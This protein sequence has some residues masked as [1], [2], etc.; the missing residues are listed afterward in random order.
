MSA[1]TTADPAAQELDFL[2]CRT[3]IL[4]DTDDTAGRFGL[5][6]SIEVPAGHMPPVH[7][8][9]AQDEGLYVLEGAVTFFM[10]GRSVDC[11]RGDFLLAP[12]GVPHAYRVGDRPARWLV[13][14]SPAGF[15]RFVAEVASLQEVDPATLTAAAA[16]YD[17]EILGP[18][19]TLP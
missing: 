1:T 15:E 8:H 18:P 10:P 16:T 2:G 5:V 19:G 14:S 3:R 11:S 7:V 12:R 9:H 6:D 4:V 17:I 13:I